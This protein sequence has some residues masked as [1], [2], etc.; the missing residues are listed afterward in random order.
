MKPDKKSIVIAISVL[1]TVI[2]LVA[3]VF[4][5]YKSPTG[6]YAREHA[7]I[8]ALEANEETPYVNLDGEPVSLSAYVGTPLLV[9]VWA[10][11]S[12]FAKDELPFLS[13]IGARYGEKI[14]IIGLNRMEDK[15][16]AIAYLASINKPQNIIYLVDPTDY[17]FKTVNGYAMPET[18]LFDEIG[19]IVL[20]KHGT[21]SKDELES[22]LET[23]IKQ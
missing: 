4:Y 16:R 10:S 22:A 23:L 9:N 3:F 21:L 18:L 13:E 15:E 5:Q 1:G 14:T 8:Q 11:W 6:F 2:A 17:F 7:D 12:P 20:H 19:N